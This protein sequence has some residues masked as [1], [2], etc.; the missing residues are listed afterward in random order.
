MSRMMVN[1]DYGQAY[2]DCSVTVI[3]YIKMTK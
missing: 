1:F 2:L 3:F